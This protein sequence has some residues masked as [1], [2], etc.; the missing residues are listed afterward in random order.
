MK[1]FFYYLIWIICVVLAMVIMSTVLMLFLAPDSIGVKGLT[2]GAGL[3][4]LYVR[5]DLFKLLDKV[6][7]KKES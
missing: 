5:K 1:K 7:S 3:A 2:A 4:V 6:F